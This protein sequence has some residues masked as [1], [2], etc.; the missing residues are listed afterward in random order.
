MLLRG[1][2]LERLVFLLPHL[3]DLEDEVGLVVAHFRL[4]R[5]EQEHR[6]RRIFVFGA[7]LVAHGLRHHAGF[8][9]EMRGVGMIEIVG[10]LERVGEHEGRIGLAIDVDHAV[11]M[12][13]G[14]LER[15]VAAIEELDLG[16]EQGGGA[17]GLVLA[18]GLHLFQRRARLLPG[19]LAFAALAE[20][21]ADDLDPVAALGVQRDGA[22]RAPD[23]IARM[24]GDDEPGL[25]FRHETTPF[26]VRAL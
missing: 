25:L 17:F 10:V 23:E 19:E 9:R 26:S 5:L 16:A 1:E 8:L 6:R 18:A 15:I 4:V 13:L 22:A 20:R 14:E 11:E 12:L 7:R 3:V 24:G 21:Q 2:D